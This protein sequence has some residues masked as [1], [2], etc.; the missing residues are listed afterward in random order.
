MVKK[1]GWGE[2]EEGKNQQVVTEGP[3]GRSSSE[4]LNLLHNPII[5]QVNEGLWGQ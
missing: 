4:E 1:R 3:A 5:E 2:E